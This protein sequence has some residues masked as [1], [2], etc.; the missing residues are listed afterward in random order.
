LYPEAKKLGSQLKY[1]DQRGFRV[2]LVAGPS[3]L[4]AGTCQ[5]KNLA[6]KSSQELPW[7]ESP[8]QLIEAIR[9]IL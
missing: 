9:K 3:E 8:A 7:R 4:A 6:D 1:A 2:A 5:V